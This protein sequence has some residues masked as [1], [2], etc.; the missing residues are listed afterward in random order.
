MLMAE[1]HP[2]E[3]DRTFVIADLSATWRSPKARK[4]ST[5]EDLVW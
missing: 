4:V 5:S 2:N 1:A 3:V